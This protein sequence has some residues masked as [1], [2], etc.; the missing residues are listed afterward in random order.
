MRKNMHDFKLPQHFNLQDSMQT[1]YA[2]G[3]YFIRL[4]YRAEDSFE[5]SYH[6]FVRDPDGQVRDLTSDAEKRHK[7]VNFQGEILAELSQ[8][9]QR[10][11]KIMDIG[12]GPGWLLS[13]LDCHWEKY[14]VEISKFAAE[15]AQEHGVIYNVSIE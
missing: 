15:I 1:L 12:C 10:R 5:E 3:D 6:S 13:A 8:F 11:L 14:G 7:L 2:T 4:K 9:P